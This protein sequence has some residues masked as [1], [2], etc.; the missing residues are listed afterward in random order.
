MVT[1]VPVVHKSYL[2]ICYISVIM[3]MTNQFLGET[4]L[5]AAAQSSFLSRILNLP[6]T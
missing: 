1:T 6:K 2:H 4:S 3:I 5:V